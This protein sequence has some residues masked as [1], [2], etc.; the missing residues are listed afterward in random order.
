MIE[1]KCDNCGSRESVISCD[2]RQ[3]SVPVEGGSMDVDVKIYRIA[4]GKIADLCPDCRRKVYKSISELAR[5]V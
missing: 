5:T 3:A 2:Y 1:R 4:S